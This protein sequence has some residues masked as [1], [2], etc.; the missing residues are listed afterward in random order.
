MSSNVYRVGDE[1]S[2]NVYRV[3]DELKTLNDDIKEVDVYNGIDFHEHDKQS[4]PNHQACNGV[5]TT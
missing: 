4:H 2:S 3:G 1:M 5:K